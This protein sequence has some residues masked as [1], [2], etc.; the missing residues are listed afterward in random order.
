MNEEV[1]SR[2]GLLR[3]KKEKNL[4][5]ES[6]RTKQTSELTGSRKN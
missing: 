2:W 4:K 1:M 5:Q 3:Q 6:K